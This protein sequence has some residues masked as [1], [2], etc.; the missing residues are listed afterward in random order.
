M[1][2]GLLSKPEASPQGLKNEFLIWL[3]AVQVKPEAARVHAVKDFFG[4]VLHRL[5][6]RDKGI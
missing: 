2:I 5:A 4:S 1:P 3:H 6:K